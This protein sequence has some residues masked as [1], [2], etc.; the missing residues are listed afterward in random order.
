[1]ASVSLKCGKQYLNA[2]GENSMVF[3]CI[4]T[5]YVDI[6]TLLKLT[7]TIGTF[8]KPHE[9]LKTFR[10]THYHIKLFRKPHETLKTSNFR[11][12]M[13]Y[14]CSKKDLKRWQVY[15]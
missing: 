1:M 12:S 15:H 4:S 7:K 13:L 8:Q 10:K 11:F 5:K 9:T 6:E 14:Y 2:K 3:G